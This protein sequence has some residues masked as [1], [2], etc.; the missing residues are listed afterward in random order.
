MDAYAQAVLVLTGLIVLSGA[1]VVAW[2]IA[3]DERYMNTW[4]DDHEL[5]RRR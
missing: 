3:T 4:K 5:R 1:V 2:C